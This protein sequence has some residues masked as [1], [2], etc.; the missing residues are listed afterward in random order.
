[1]SLLALMLVCGQEANYPLTDFPPAH[2][3]VAINC[4]V[5]LY[6]RRLRALALVAVAVVFPQQTHIGRR[7]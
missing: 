4:F 7:R 2:L 6:Y 5:L 1:M 3:I